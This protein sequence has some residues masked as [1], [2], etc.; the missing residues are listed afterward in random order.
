MPA[1][2][3]GG[4]LVGGM[5]PHDWRSYLAQIYPP[6][7]AGELGGAL[8]QGDISG[9]PLIGRIPEIM[10]QRTRHLGFQRNGI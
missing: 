8:A 2:E 3:A 10:R 7:A 9:I 1:V 6:A 4:E 5:M